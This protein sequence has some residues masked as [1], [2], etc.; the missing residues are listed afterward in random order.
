MSKN[1]ADKTNNKV[2]D[3]SPKTDYDN[4]TKEELIHNLKDFEEKIKLETEDKKKISEKRK[5]NLMQ[6]IL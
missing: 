3:E 2:E 6:K 1:P 5:K 4:F